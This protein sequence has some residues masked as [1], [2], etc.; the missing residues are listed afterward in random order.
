MKQDNLCPICGDGELQHKT[1]ITK[2]E[3]NG[4]EGE[5]V[6][7]FSEC[8][9]CGC[10]TASEQDMKLNSRNMNSFKK[11]CLGLLTGKQILSIRK[12]LNISQKDAAEIFGGG[13]NSFT[14]YENDDVIQSVAMDR[15]IRAAHK[16]EAVFLDLCD[17]AGLSKNKVFISKWINESLHPPIS[18]SGSD[19]NIYHNK[20]LIKD[21]SC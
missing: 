20:K 15:L 4:V 21:L 17:S 12:E 19:W 6:I 13:P 2:R 3:F 8:S 16:H 10:E 11:K 7:H 9:E 1:T 5:I 14:K 18:T